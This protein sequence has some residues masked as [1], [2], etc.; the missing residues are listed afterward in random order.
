M[1]NYP[2]VSLETSGGLE[3]TRYQDEVNNVKYGKYFFVQRA[4]SV[5]HLPIGD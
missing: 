1:V 4:I 2:T 3:S 5:V